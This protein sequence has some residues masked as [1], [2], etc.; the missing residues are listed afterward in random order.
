[1]T[2]EQDLNDSLARLGEKIIARQQEYEDL[3]CIARR[4]RDTLILIHEAEFGYGGWPTPTEEEI[5]TLLVSPAVQALGDI[6]VSY[7]QEATN[8]KEKG[9]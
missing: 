7:I 6:Y 5:K 4:L 8:I 9:K 3:L 1:M 2:T